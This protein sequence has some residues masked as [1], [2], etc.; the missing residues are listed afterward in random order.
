MAA[1]QPVSVIIATYNRPDHLRRCLTQLE[2]QSRPADQIIVVDASESGESERV[3]AEHPR[4]QYLRNNSGPGST[5]TSRAIGVRAAHG[6]IV[7]FL[8][9]DAYPHADWLEN[10]L[11]PYEDATVA[12]VGGRALNGN[13]G[14]ES[15]GIGEIGLLL[16]NGTLTGHFAAHPGKTVPVDHMLG[17][18]MSVRRSIIDEL[19]GIHD[20]Y[21]GTC[22]REETDIAL[23]IRG[24]GYHIL[25]TPFAVVDHIPGPYA[26]GRRFDTRYKFYGTRNHV[27]LLSRTLGMSDPHLR[28]YIA[29]E[30][31]EILGD[32]RAAASSPFDR[33][34]PGVATKMRGVLGGVERA[35]SKQAGLVVGLTR[36]TVLRI[37][38]GAVPAPTRFG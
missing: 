13:P 37:R 33:S 10:L 9:D 26:R 16:P 8:D 6:V 17:A 18:N 3:V 21:P 30:E 12:A 27:V 32:L 23:R 34:R 7:A 35:L 5:A 14:E 4:V 28:R 19:G 25:F 24:A 2:Q 20:Y 15:V 29:R 31:M 22:L 11:K 38:D 1:D 36:S